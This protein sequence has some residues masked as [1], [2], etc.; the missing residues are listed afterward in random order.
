MKRATIVILIACCV[1]AAATAVAQEKKYGSGVSLTTATTV[2]NLLA[3]PDKYLGK[4]VRVDGIITGVCEMAGCWM[5]LADPNADV[6]SAKTLRFK[7]DDGVIVF[8]VS[9][10]GKKGSAEGV[11]E[12]V[13]GE[14]ASEY[15]ADQEKSKGGDTKNAVPSFQ[16]K[17]VGAVIY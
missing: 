14:M 10:K 9:A 12:K 17:A 15:A 11:F 4:T 16:V 6:K 2:A 3:Q 5:E 13:S 1:V 8:P 7:V